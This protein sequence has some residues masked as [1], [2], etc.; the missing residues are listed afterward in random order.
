MSGSRV[1]RI[2]NGCREV[3]PAPR[4]RLWRFRLRGAACRS[5]ILFPDPGRWRGTGCRPLRTRR[6][7]H[8]TRTRC[9]SAALRFERVQE[10]TVHQDD[11]TVESHRNATY[12]P[13]SAWS[14]KG[15]SRTAPDVARCGSPACAR[16]DPHEGNEGREPGSRTSTRIGR[17]HQAGHGDPALRRPVYL[18][19]VVQGTV[20]GR[21]VRVALRCDSIRRLPVRVSRAEGGRWQLAGVAA[22]MLSQTASNGAPQ[23]WHLAAGAPSATR[24]NPWPNGQRTR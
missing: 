17:E 10:S 8:G 2:R 9:V 20:R 3:A 6:A 11:P 16:R 24:N 19:H 5:R 22:T 12:P 7:D 23:A 1:S 13:S 15:C 14:G 4:G 21:A 18:A